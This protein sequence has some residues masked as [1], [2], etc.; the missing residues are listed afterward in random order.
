MEFC[1]KLQV[2]L[3]IHREQKKKIQV[4]HKAQDGSK[5][6]KGNEFLISNLWESQ[7]H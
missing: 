6:Q 3:R 2:T 1:L 4:I 5:Q 7:E